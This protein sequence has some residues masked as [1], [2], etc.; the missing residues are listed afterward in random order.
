MSNVNPGVLVVVAACV[1]VAVAP[2]VSRAQDGGAQ[3][4]PTSRT[5]IIEQ[6]QAEKATQ[7]NPSEPSRAEQVINNLEEAML[8]D[9]I[10]I[11]PYF[12]SAYAGGGFT[13]G[14]G[15]RRH[16][17]AYNLVDVRGSF[18]VKGYTRVE[19]AFMAPRL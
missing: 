4:P 2:A 9:S 7:L 15:Y 14:V 1:L 13:M 12:E 18:T 8:A 17:S 6:A 11:H 10:H 19:G 3:P 5:A 16:V